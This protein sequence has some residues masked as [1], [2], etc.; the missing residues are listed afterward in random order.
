M[1][2]HIIERDGLRGQGV[3][4]RAVGAGIG[5]ILGLF[6]PV[7]LKGP[8]PSRFIDPVFE[9]CIDGNNA[10]EPFELVEHAVDGAGL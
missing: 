6:G 10:F 1:T 4:R 8:P 2:T 5:L 3:L 9:A 7:A